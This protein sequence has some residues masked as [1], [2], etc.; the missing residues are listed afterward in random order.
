MATV[1]L[2]VCLGFPALHDERYVAALR[3]LPGV[4][5]VILPVD[6]N[7]EWLTVNPGEPHAEPPPWAG[8]VA[9][10]RRAALGR[11]QALVA[12]HTPRDLLE[13]APSLRWIQ[14]CGAGVEQFA[15]AGVTRERTVVTN[16]SGVSAGS[17][18]EWVVGRLLQVWKRFRE[19][20]A[21]QHE[22]TFTRT[23]GR[24]L[25]GSTIGIIGLGHIGRAVS[26]RARAFGCRV[27][28][29]KRSAAPGASSEHA[30]QL[31]PPHQLHEMIARCDAVIVSAPATPETRHLIDAE[32]LAAMQPHAVLVNVARGS[33]VDE[34]ALAKAIEAG[35]IGA[36]VLDVFDQE[37]LQSDSPLWDLP[38]VYLS[39]HSS[40]SVDRYVD[41]VFRIVLENVERRL[42]G[43]PLRN[44]V[45]MKALGF[46]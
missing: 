38:G 37:P 6:P 10:A 42:A 2:V 8:G 33:L 46:A 40:V 4:E 36:A 30:D 43:R 34:V 45:D 41:D 20:D 25:A 27:L 16:V 28:A 12:L 19:A 39:A 1:E 15:L 32:A 5:P 31:Y 23:Y 22:H 44:T 11:A 9:D 7:A 29:S 24:T 17:M 13:L 3:A 21:H 18:A 26:Q 14:G 35:E